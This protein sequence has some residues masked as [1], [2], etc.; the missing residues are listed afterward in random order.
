MTDKTDTE[1][2]A[3]E[4]QNFL[5]CNSLCSLIK[6]IGDK[7]NSDANKFEKSNFIDMAFAEYSNNRF[8]LVDEVGY[9]IKDTY[10][11]RKL[12]IKSLYEGFRRKDGE[13][14]KS[15]S[16][17]LRN[18]RGKKLDKLPKTFDYLILVTVDEIIMVSHQDIT[19]NIGHKLK[20]TDS[21]VELSIDPSK[22]TLIHKIDY[23]NIKDCDFD[24][25]NSKKELQLKFIRDIKSQNN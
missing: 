20:Y 18:S 5:D 22:A 15:I 23:D 11:G 2:Y 4:I 10:Y 14:K 21:T 12:E 19:S 7:L 3:E 16:I 1:K 13:Y 6:S 24:Y 17:I 25:I 9:D 8:S